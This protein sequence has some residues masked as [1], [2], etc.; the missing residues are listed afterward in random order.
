MC[1]VF[2]LGLT[3]LISHQDH[4]HQQFIERIKCAAF[5]HT[6][7]HCRNKASDCRDIIDF[8]TTHKNILF[9]AHP[10]V[11]IFHLLRNDSRLAK[12]AMNTRLHTISFL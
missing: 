8:S 4:I 10:A 7:S 5:V 3:G 11:F 9:G 12:K 6:S 1:S 2:L